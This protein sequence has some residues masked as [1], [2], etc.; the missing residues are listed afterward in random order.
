MNESTNDAR[1]TFDP[2][3]DKTFFPQSG[4][5]EDQKYLFRLCSVAALYSESTSN[6]LVTDG[7]KFENDHR[8]L[9]SAFHHTK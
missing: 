1:Q 7:K 9:N 2:E 4:L 5:Q 6:I 3:G 8:T